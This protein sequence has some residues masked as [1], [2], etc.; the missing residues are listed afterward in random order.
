MRMNMKHTNFT[1]QAS[2]AALFLTFAGVLVAQTPSTDS[3]SMNAPELIALSIPRSMS[4]HSGPDAGPNEK[5]QTPTSLATL[6]SPNTTSLT[7]PTRVMPGTPANPT[8][9]ASKLNTVASV[10]EQS[11]KRSSLIGVQP[12]TM[13]LDVRLDPTSTQKYGAAPA[14]VQ[15]RIGRN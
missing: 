11:T 10:R 4:T 6:P 2:T 8:L 14:M 3:D 7:N 1:R 15:I 12:G 13:P 9:A 5:V